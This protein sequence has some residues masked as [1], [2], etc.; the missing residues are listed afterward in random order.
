MLVGLIVTVIALGVIAGLI[1][2][3]RAERRRKPLSEAARHAAPGDFAELSQGVTYYRWFGPKRGR[4]AIL[5]PGLTTP[6]IGL[7]K[8]A[9]G[10][11]EMGYRVLCYDLY[12]RGLS[13]TVRGRQDRAFFLQQLVDLFGYLGLREEVTVAGYSMG[14]AIATAFAAE[15]PHVVRRVMLFAPG[16]VLLRSSRFSRFCTR[17][18]L[19]GDWLHAAFAQRRF[20]RG[21]PD[22]PLNAFVGEV[23]QAQRDMLD[24]RGYL[25]AVLSSRRGMLSESLEEEHRRLGRQGIPVVAVWGGA[26]TVIPLRAVGLLGLWNRNARQEVV[27]GADHDLPYTHSDQV[28]AAL[29]IAIRNLAQ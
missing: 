17:V 24:R 6:M 13:D 15:N 25:P 1:W 11:A 4:M 10:L 9:E 2:P 27:N 19:L 7:E 23:Y 14:G 22:R 28:L 5:V 12:G 26:D 16:G 29:K 3:I 21:I 18:P 8:I 20:A